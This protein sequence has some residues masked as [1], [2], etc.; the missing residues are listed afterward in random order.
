VKVIKIAVLICYCVLPGFVFCGCEMVADTTDKTIGFVTPEGDPNDSVVRFGYDRTALKTSS[1][2]DVLGVIHLKKYEL[3]SQ[4]KSVIALQG[5]KKDAHKMWVKMVAFDEN[6]LTAQ[7]KYLFIEDE[8]PKL[9]LTDPIEGARFE[10]E[11]VLDKKLF[12]KPYANENARRIA[13]L[14]QVLE[15]FKKDILEVES[16]NK[17]LRSCGMII[18]QAIGAVVTELEDKSS[19]PALAVRLEDP[20]GIGFSHLSYSKGRAGMV[21]E[22]N[23]IIKV[24]I[25]VG[26]FTLYF[27]DEQLKKRECN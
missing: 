2:A 20:K 7:R 10:C 25:M 5:V 21:I 3:L 14:K 9:L 6:A 8:R 22:C 16:D 24:K 11:M 26:S 15:N 12:D 23:E 13:V 19:T 1:A 27:E 17:M 18:N 4:S